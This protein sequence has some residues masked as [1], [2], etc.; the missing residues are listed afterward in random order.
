MRILVLGNDGYIGW[1]LTLHLLDEGYEVCGVDNGVRRRRVENAGSDSLTKISDYVARME[2]LEDTYS[3]YIGDYGYFGLH[4][5]YNYISAYLR[6]TKPDAIVHLAEQP[7]A[8]WSMISPYTSNATQKENV[9]GTL[10]LLWAMREHC[11]DA[12]LLKLGSMGEYGTPEC[13]I[14][15]GEIP[16]ECM[17]DIPLR[18]RFMPR[19]CPLS[20]LPFPRSPNSIYHL[21]KVHDTHNIIFAC[22]TWG[23]RSTDIMQGVVFGINNPNGV[24]ERQT[25]FDYDEYFGTAINR[26]I[27][28]AIAGIPLTVYGKGDQTRGFL[29]LKDSIQ[30]LTLAL[31]NPP[32]LGEYRT[33]NQFEE[34]YTINA[35]ADTVARIGN[36][37]DLNV[38][39]QHLDNPRTELES[40]YYNPAHQK[41]FDLGYTPGE[42]E[43]EISYAMAYLA[44]NKDRIKT[45]PILPITSW[46]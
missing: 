26:F 8:P 13:D 12:H 36:T 11:P 1:P 30:C 7:S 5:G 19:E 42:M 41:L 21:S 23:L 16:V 15:E 14:P 32:S 3:N 25:R 27:A 4:A 46:R 2:Y 39:I 34:I 22:K 38:R 17:T 29:P 33:F 6:E 44:S 37:L 35:L 45:K 31:E 18:S 40:H 43:Y 10:N 24:P 20:S 9:L 28:Q